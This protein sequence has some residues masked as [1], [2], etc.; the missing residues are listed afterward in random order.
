M[1]IENQAPDYIRVIAPY[2]GGRPI[3]EIARLYGFTEDSIVKL[4]SNENPLGMSPRARQAMLDASADLGRYPDGNGHDL[5]LAISRRFDLPMDWI[6]LGNGSNDILEA[7]AA[8][9]LNPQASC[10]YSQHSFAVYAL[11]PQARGAQAIVVPARDYGHDLAAMAAAIRP[12][13]RLVF[14]AN[15][16]NP[17][18][19]FLPAPA[20]AAFLAQ[21]PRAV[22][23]VLDEA[24]NEYLPPE[25]RYDSVAWVRQHPNLIVS[26]SF[27]KAYGLAALRVG[28]GVMD[29]TVADLLN[30]VRQP[31]NVN[32]LAQAAAAAALDDADY[33]ARSYALNREGLRTLTAGFDRLGLDYVPPFGNFVLVKVGPAARVYQE[34]LRRGVIVRPVANYGLPEWL[35]VTVGLEAE[36][37]RFLDVLPPALAAAQAQ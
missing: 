26:R 30:R 2:Q 5:K 37:A 19:T 31:F 27:S 25:L 6:T 20:L 14:I 15:P 17:T 22:V 24:Y 18:G 3:A 1:S 10:V 4:A 33:L 34:L 23:V 7:A 28:Y 36:N 9:T 13:T 8:V 12:H 32:S 21:M 11:A 29:A 35:R 16:N